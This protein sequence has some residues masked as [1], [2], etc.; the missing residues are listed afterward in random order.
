[1]GNHQ[2]RHLREELAMARLTILSVQ[3]VILVACSDVRIEDGDDGATTSGEGAGSSPSPQERFV[4]ACEARRARHGCLNY[5]CTEDEA[6]SL[7]DFWSDFPGCFEALISVLACSATD[8]PNCG[9]CGTEEEAQAWEDC[10]IALSESQG[11]VGGGGAA[12]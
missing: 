10:G 11:Q 4:E 8:S 5:E 7:E 12:P 1:M 2:A 9:I 6:A 3:A